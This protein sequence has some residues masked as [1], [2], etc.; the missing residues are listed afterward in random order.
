MFF[1]MSVFSDLVDLK[2]VQ[3][4]R[5]SDRF[6]FV[7]QIDDYFIK[8]SRNGARYA[9]IDFADDSS[10]I[11]GM[12]GDF[13]DRLNLT[14]FLSSYKLQKDQIVIANAS[15]SRDGETLFIDNMSCISEKV[16]SK[17]KELNE[18]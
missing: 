6:R 3:I 15:F 4:D 7:A 13:G 2:S 1:L 9:K 17:L 12:I 5:P 18:K 14:N 8:T 10:T 16:Y 11:T